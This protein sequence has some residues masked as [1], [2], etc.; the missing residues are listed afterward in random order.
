MTGEPDH[1]RLRSPAGG[2]GPRCVT[3]GPAANLRHTPGR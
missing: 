3:R 2:S 1:Q